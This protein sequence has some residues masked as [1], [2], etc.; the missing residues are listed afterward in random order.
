MK[1]V[2]CHTNRCFRDVHD[3]LL[4][5]VL[6]ETAQELSALKPP[7]G[8][9]EVWSKGIASQSVLEKLSEFLVQDFWIPSCWW[10]CLGLTFMERVLLCRVAR[11]EVHRPQFLCSCASRW[12]TVQN[13]RSHT[14]THLTVLFGTLFSRSSPAQSSGQYPLADGIP[15]AACACFELVNDKS[16]FA[17]LLVN[18]RWYE[19]IHGLRPSIDD[20]SARYDRCC[21]LP[22]ARQFSSRI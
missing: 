8:R 15:I 17:P 18:L 22:H 21:W 19:G 7:H 3:I 6:R 16:S 9:F 5:H 13:K 1:Q 10:R 14:F 20:L 4:R 11:W 2:R 12:D